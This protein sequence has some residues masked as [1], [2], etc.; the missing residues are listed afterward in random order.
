[1]SSI[2]ISFLMVPIMVC[3]TILIV[4]LV[5]DIMLSG[6]RLS[7][8][9]FILMVA[10][11]LLHPPASHPCCRKEQRRSEKKIKYFLSKKFPITYY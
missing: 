9:A 2:I 8:G 10:R 1:M 4:F 11:R 3:F 7:L 5:K 6:T